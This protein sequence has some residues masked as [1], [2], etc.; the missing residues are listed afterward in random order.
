MGNDM[1]DQM[2]RGLQDLMRDSA[3][4][5]ALLQMQQPG[6]VPFLTPVA[7]EH[8]GLEIVYDCKGRYDLWRNGQPVKSSLTHAELGEYLQHGRSDEEVEK[9]IG[10]WTRDTFEYWGIPKRAV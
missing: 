5:G 6:D 8:R 9:S 10:Q 4:W 7:P 2:R 3:G 1:H